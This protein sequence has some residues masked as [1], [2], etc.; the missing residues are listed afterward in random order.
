MVEPVLIE[1]ETGNYLL[2]IVY[3]SA[4]DKSVVYLLNAETLQDIYTAELPKVVPLSFHGKW[5]S[6]KIV[7]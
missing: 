3:H 6:A 5:D 2:T 1:H 4:T 7:A